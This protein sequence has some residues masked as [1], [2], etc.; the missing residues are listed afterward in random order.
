MRIAYLLAEDLSRHPGLKHK[1]D[2]QISRWAKDGHDVY[3]VMHFAGSVIGPDGHL[4]NFDQVLATPPTVKGKIWQLL[5]LSR[6]HAFAASALKSIQPDITYSRY[7]FPSWDVQKIAS[8]AGKLIIEI[9][10]NDISEFAAKHILTGAFNKIFRGKVLSM[11]NGLVFVTR[12]LA[13]SPAF[14]SFTKRRIVLANG[15]ESTLFSFVQNPGNAK[16]QLVFI[17]SPGQLWHGLNKLISLSKILTE[18]TIHV[19]GPGKQECLDLWG[20]LPT[21][22]MIHGYLNA[23]DAQ[24]LTS[25]MDVGISTLALHR[26]KMN[27]ACPLKV[28]QYL[29]QGLP[30][31]A[32]SED[33]DIPDNQ[34]FYLRLPNCENNITQS[35]QRI[36]DFVYEAFGNTALRKKAREFAMVAMGVDSKESERLRFFQLHLN[37]S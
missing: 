13:C 14:S 17:G 28:R 21:N 5:R 2:G 26:N 25:R 6:Q 23:A 7:L 8:H 34:S 10:S 3:R 27:E 30:V 20:E 24:E 33:T 31:L 19:I 37:E 11:A 4:R 9:N 22:V 32:A 29:A 1:I 16:P 18:C 15:V 35:A 36:S 12:E